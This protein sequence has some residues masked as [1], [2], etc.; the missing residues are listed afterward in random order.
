MWADENETESLAIQGLAPIYIDANPA[1]SSSWGGRVNDGF[2]RGAHLRAE[3]VPHSDRV[4]LVAIAPA[5]V[6]E[7]L[8][9][10][11]GPDYWQGHYDSLPPSVQDEARTHYDLTIIE[12]TCYTPE[13]RRCALREGLIHRIGKRW[14]G[15]PPTTKGRT[16]RPPAPPTYPRLPPPPLPTHGQQGRSREPE[17]NLTPAPVSGPTPG[18][19]RNPARLARVPLATPGAPTVPGP[20][21]PPSPRTLTG[22]PPASS[23][24][25]TPAGPHGLPLAPHCSPTAPRPPPPQEPST[26]AR[27]LPRPQPR[28]GC[29]PPRPGPPQSRTR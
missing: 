27:D 1:V 18:T 16:R 17:S 2:H 7:E 20:D 11:Y 21:D 28:T 15:G 3:R 4:R 19:H 29:P 9:L 8:Y 25:V 22:P 6:G 26:Q 23:R 24:T 5:A 12:G 14:Y 13:Q 10:E